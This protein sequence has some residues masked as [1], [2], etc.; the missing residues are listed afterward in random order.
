MD[1]EYSKEECKALDKK[2]EHPDRIVRC[3]R[4]GNVLIYKK[5]GN[6]CEVRCMTVNCIYDAIRGL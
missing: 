3:P 4:C 2:F 6:S 5:N 1:T